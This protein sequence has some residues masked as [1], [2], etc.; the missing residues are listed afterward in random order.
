MSRKRGWIAVLLAVVGLAGGIG[1]GL[2]YGWEIDPVSY[3]DTEIAHLHPLY[4]DEYI[5]MVSKAYALDGDL[6][7]ARARIA[8]LAP[9]DPANAVADLA[10]RTIAQNAPPPQIRVLAEMA[11]AMGAGRETFRPY[12]PVDE[13]P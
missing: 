10:E 12:L 2:W 8:L 5:L 9:A 11:D 3:T 13:G 6:D 7:T 1:L 4:R